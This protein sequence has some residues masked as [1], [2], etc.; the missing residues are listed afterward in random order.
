MFISCLSF[1]FLFLSFLYIH[2]IIHL[3]SFMKKFSFVYLH[4]YFFCL[5][6]GTLFPYVTRSNPIYIQRS[7]SFFS[8]THLWF[9]QKF[10]YI[11]SFTHIRL[12]LHVFFYKKTLLCTFSLFLIYADIYSLHFSSFLSWFWFILFLKRRS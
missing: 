3:W 7:F 5:R 9:I 6:I 4:S 12:P 11:Y 10:L 2:K 1:F 8:N